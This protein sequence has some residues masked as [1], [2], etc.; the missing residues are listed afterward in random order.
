MKSSRYTSKWAR[1][2]ACECGDRDSQLLLDSIVAPAS[3]AEICG[4]LV[5]DKSSRELRWRGVARGEGVKCAVLDYI[6][7]YT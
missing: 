2:V 4:G 3:S 6:C 1:A 5:S 7:S